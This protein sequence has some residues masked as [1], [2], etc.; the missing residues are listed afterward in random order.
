MAYTINHTPSAY[1][2]F[3]IYYNS[4]PRELAKDRPV[5]NTYSLNQLAEPDLYLLPIQEEI[6]NMLIGCDYISIIDMAKFFY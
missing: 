3:I 2:V 6:I 5:V 1:L 4:K